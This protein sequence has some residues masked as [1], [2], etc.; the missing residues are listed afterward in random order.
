MALHPALARLAWIVGR[1]RGGGHGVFPTIKAFDYVETVS[2]GSCG[3]PFLTYTGRTSHPVEKSP[4][5][6][7]DGFWKVCPGTDKIA[8]ALSQNTGVTEHLEGIVSADGQSVHLISTA[9]HGPSFGKEPH[10]TKVERLYERVSDNELK[11]TLKMATEN[12]PELT[13]HLTGQLTRD[14]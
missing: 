12:T 7:E 9:V 13:L 11:Y 2:F 8:V 4:M 10:V 1:W 14:D 5:H 6:A 3:K